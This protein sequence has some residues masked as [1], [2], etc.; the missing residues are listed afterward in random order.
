[1]AGRARRF[2]IFTAVCA[3]GLALAA[4]G[5]RPAAQT[6]ALPR[7]PLSAYATETRD[8]V[9][10]MLKAAAARPTDAS[11][12]GALGRTLQAWQQWDAAHEA[13]RRAQTL[14]P[15]AARADRRVAPAYG[16]LLYQRAG[17]GI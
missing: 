14:E 16:G 4:P 8:A 5:S 9:E 6:P 3:A 10:P 11:A 1:M 7:L 2:F 13:F 15:A 17:K 12:A